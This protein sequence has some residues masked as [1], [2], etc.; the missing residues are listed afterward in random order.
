M[1]FRLTLIRRR[2]VVLGA[3]LAA[4]G[5]G[6]TGAASTGDVLAVQTAYVPIR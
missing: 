2:S 1:M 5:S 6:A 3:L 4:L